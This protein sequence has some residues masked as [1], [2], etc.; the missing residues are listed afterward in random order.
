MA[1]QNTAG[2]HKPP[3]QDAVLLNRLQ[4][5]QRTARIVPARGRQHGGDQAA[6][7]RDQGDSRA[8][9]R[10]SPAQI[11]PS[12]PGP[13]RCTC[14]ARGRTRT[15]ALR[16][17]PRRPPAARIPPGPGCPAPPAARRRKPPSTAC[18]PCSGSRRPRPCATQRVPVAGYP[19]RSEKRARRTILL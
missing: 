11:T 7:E 8:L 15:R 2:P 10:R 14:A 5:V 17:R 4:H 9:H 16:R 19:A 13:S 12:D 1:A 6:V 18:E 3:S